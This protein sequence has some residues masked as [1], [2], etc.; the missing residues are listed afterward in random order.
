MSVEDVR[1]GL[2]LATGLVSLVAGGPA[3]AACDPVAPPEGGV[4][5]QPGGMQDPTPTV[6]GPMEQAQHSPG[7]AHS[8][9]ETPRAG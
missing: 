9:H 2:L 8:P 7:D 1:K 4:V 5:Q 3:L 6:G